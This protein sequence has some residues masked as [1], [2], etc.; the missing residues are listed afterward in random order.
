MMAVIPVSFYIIDP[1]TIT[2]AMLVSSTTVEP[3]SG[4]V[5]WN[6]ATNYAI[7]D[8]A[9]L[10][11][12]HTIYNRRTVGITAGSP[13]VDTTN[14]TLVGPTNRWAMFDQSVGTSTTGSGTLEVV[15]RPGQV[16]ALH[17]DDMA[18]LTLS[19]SMK[20]QP[21]G[22]V[23]YTAEVD[24]DDTQIADVYEW[25]FTP[26][27][28]KTTAN[29]IDL[30]TQWFD[31]EIT[32]TI[33]GTGTVECG[34]LRVGALHGVGGTLMGASISIIDYSRKDTDDFGI[35]RFVER[36]FSKR[37]SSTV[38]TSR[39]EFRRVFRLLAGLRAREAVYIASTVDELEPLTIRGI[40]A[41]WSIDCESVNHVQCNLIVEGISQ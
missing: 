21:G 20:S 17:M 5:A 27:V 40:P 37:L 10:A 18:G 8:R 9:Y 29:L 11:S 32:V 15:L 16:G 41:D 3:V 12:T 6:A 2:D 30:P 39:S 34:V 22:T 31:P 36:S 23:V 28:Q 19:V 33:S 38:I 35:T 1:T 13:D 25:F 7:N 26:F 4:E 14:W 24:L